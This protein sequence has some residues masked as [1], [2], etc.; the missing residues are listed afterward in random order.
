MMK[1][2]KVVEGDKKDLIYSW[3]YG[4]LS[5]FFPLTLLLFDPLTFFGIVSTG[6]FDGMFV[7]FFLYS[8]IEYSDSRKVYWRKIK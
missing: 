5:I 6:F 8:I 7:L 4:L 3:F 2:E 1:F